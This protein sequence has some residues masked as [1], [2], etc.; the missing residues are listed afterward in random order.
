MKNG[1]RVRIDVPGGAQAV[2]KQYTLSRFFD[3]TYEYLQQAPY[4]YLE[5]M[6]RAG[7]ADTFKSR[8]GNPPSP[9]IGGG[10]AQQCLAETQQFYKSQ[11]G[12]ERFRQDLDKRKNVRFGVLITYPL[13]ETGKKGST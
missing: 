6:G 12:N 7:S 4:A 3:T 9:W 13:Q 11:K 5:A 8:T 10:S 1:F 2:G